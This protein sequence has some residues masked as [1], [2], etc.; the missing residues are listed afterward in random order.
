MFTVK[1]MPIKSFD[2]GKRWF[3]Y[4]IRKQFDNA[5]TAVGYVIAQSEKHPTIVYALFDT[6]CFDTSL[7]GLYIDGIQFLVSTV[8]K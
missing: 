6:N 3:D 4:P 2:K 1:S 7:L 8:E 5:Y